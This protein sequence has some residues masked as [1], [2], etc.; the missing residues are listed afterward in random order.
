MPYSHEA[1]QTLHMV[2]AKHIAYQTLAF[3]QSEL[4]AHAGHYTGRIL[5]SVL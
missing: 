3:A 2:L 4:P 1:L 5:P